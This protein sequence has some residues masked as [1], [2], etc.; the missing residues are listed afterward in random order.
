MSP[1]LKTAAA[2]PVQHAQRQ[3]PAQFVRYTP[4]QQSGLYA[5]GAQQRI[6]RIVE[7][8]KDPMEPPRFQSILIF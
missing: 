1:S 4:S 7:E 5:S 6:I 3:A 8:Q 2:L